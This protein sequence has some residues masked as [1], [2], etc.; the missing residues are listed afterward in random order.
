MENKGYR[1]MTFMCSK[2]RY[3]S[4]TSSQAINNG[5]RIKGI[6]I[7]GIQIS[8]YVWFKEWRD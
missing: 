5:Q 4:N 3:D 2:E 6:R 1:D 7:L 8:T